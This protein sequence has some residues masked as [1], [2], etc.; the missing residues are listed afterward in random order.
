MRLRVEITRSLTLSTGARVSLLVR[1]RVE[2]GVHEKK[3]YRYSIS[4]LL[5]FDVLN[6][7]LVY[8][9]NE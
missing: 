4:C 1:L 7:I 8:N 5:R 2:I 9:I 3:E 6:E